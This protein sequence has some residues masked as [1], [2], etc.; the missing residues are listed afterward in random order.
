MTKKILFSLLIGAFLSVPLY[1]DIDLTFEF[2]DSG[3]TTPIT[4][5]L[6]IGD[7]FDMVILG[8]DTVGAGVGTFSLEWFFGNSVLSQG[9]V[10]INTAQFPQV[11]TN[12][13][14]ATGGIMASN[15]FNAPVNNPEVLGRVSYTATAIGCSDF[16]MMGA[17]QNNNPDAT[18]FSAGDSTMG[19][20][21][22]FFTDGTCDPLAQV[23][24]TGETVNFGTGK[25]TVVPE[26]AGFALAMLSG[27]GLLLFRRRS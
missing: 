8:E 13:T 10:T 12:T 18:V 25:I 6:M 21:R 3:T 20:G 19:M 16:S 5:P 1:A 26:P 9:A 7:T 22:T 15:A 4:Q 23:A 24:C 27:L 17:L 14:S 11:L 2:Y